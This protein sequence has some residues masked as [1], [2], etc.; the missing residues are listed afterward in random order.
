MYINAVN[1]F[2]TAKATYS[3][4]INAPWPRLALPNFD[5]YESLINCLAKFPYRADPVGG[6]ADYYTHPETAQYCQ[7]NNCWGTVAFD[8]DDSAAYAHLALTKMGYVCMMMNLLVGPLD[9]FNYRKNHVICLFRHKQ[10][11]H[12]WGVI[13][14]HPFIHWVD[15]ALG[16]RDAM[17]IAEFSRRYGVK[18]EYLIPVQYPF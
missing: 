6:L 17:V 10:H 3:K 16:E 5:G 12:W 15:T 8:C 9:F 7:K 1:T 14:T 13:D 11:T 2:L 18:Y 4:A